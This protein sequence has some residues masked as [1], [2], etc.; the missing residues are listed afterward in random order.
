MIQLDDF[1]RSYLQLSLEI[2]KHIDGYV[3]AYIGPEALKT[4]VQAT[5]KRDPTSLL[6]DLSRLQDNLPTDPPHRHRY[7]KGVLRA[8]DCTIRMLTGET[9]DYLD[10]VNRFFDIQPQLLDEEKFLAAQRE[11]DTLLP[12]EGSLAERMKAP[13][14][15]IRTET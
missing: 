10:E 15:K 5:P 4:A 2:D 14:Q 7:L 8:M 6:D 3:D 12:G 1:S 11:L 9:F 13:T